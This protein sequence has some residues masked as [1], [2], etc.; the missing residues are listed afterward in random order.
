[1]CLIFTAVWNKSSILWSV[2]L[3]LQNFFMSLT[4]SIEYDTIVIFCDSLL[5]QIYN[6]WEF[7]GYWDMIFV[8]IIQSKLPIAQIFGINILKK[9]LR[10]IVSHN[11]TIKKGK[12]FCSWL[13]VPKN[14][15]RYYCTRIISELSS[16]SILS[17]LLNIILMHFLHFEE[18]SLPLPFYLLQCAK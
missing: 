12:D 17:C 1:M 15:S 7:F 16:L 6:K 8:R 18:T 9:I 14:H 10:P 4:F 2:I 3:P 5:Y 11:S 13:Q